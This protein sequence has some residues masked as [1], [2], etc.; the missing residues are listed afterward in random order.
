M[1]NVGEEILLRAL[2][3]A[4]F[5]AHAVERLRDCLH[6][7]WTADRHGLVVMPFRDFG[8]CFSDSL[9]RLGDAA[10][11]EHR[12]QNGDDQ[13]DDCRLHEQ[14]KQFCSELGERVAE[15]LC[16]ARVCEEE[17]VSILA[18]AQTFNADE[19]PF[20]AVGV[21]E[22]AAHRV[23]A[24]E[25]IERERIGNRVWFGSAI[26]LST[27]LVCAGT[28]IKHCQVVNID[29]QDAHLPL[30]GKLR[31]RTTETIEVA[32]GWEQL[33]EAEHVEKVDAEHKAGQ[34]LVG[35]FGRRVAG[36]EN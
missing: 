36:V 11:D 9:Q 15:G 21:G 4:H 29:Q 20:F 12:Q 6:F 17:G 2:F 10:G 25:H 8:G 24:A 3:G 32:L 22:R 14:R 31:E 13:P 19:E 1:R 35:G 16:G 18:L 28:V 30:G 23:D 7:F 26:Q 27:A 5:F 34:L 33:V